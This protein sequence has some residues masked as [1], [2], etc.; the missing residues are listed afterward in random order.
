MTILLEETRV[1]PLIK[2]FQQLRKLTVSKT[3]FFALSITTFTPLSY[4]QRN[5]AK[6]WVTEIRYL[7]VTVSALGQFIGKRAE[8][9]C[10]ETPPI[11]GCCLVMINKTNRVSFRLELRFSNQFKLR[12]FSAIFC[13]HIGI[14][15]DVLCHK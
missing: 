2:L 13:H 15:A 11:R 4:N 1:A 12:F 3:A 5:K 6:K 7:I 10:Q 14:C 8:G 9:A